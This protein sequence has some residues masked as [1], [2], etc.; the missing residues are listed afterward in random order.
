MKRLMVLLTCLVTVNSALCEKV[1][2]EAYVHDGFFLRLAPG[3]G[4]NTT[5]SD[6]G[7]NSLKM[8][9]ASGIFNFAIG[10]AVA[11]DLILHLDVTGVNTPDPKVTSNGNQLSSNV[12]SAST[13]LAGIGVTY[14]FP[15]NI[16][17]TGSLGIAES[18]YE[19]NGIEY[20]TDKGL[21]A[22]VMVGK[23]W[24]VSDDWGLGIAGLFLYTNCPAKSVAGARP[25][26]KSTTIG[27]L[28]S[29]TYN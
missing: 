10:G 22:N 29:A 16:Y 17:A 12:T 5:S 27:V 28:F 23:E 3:F 8:T 20:K 21:G 26:V 15:T 1:Y 13:S 18:K 11:Q 14:Y 24:W 9:G 19:S 4:W 6:S 25:D 7:G 2:A